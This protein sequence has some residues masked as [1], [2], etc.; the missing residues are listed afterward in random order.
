MALIW[1]GLA[2]LSLFG[3]GAI[4]YWVRRSDEHLTVGVVMMILALGFLGLLMFAVALTA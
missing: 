2:L 3:A 4:I 1:Y